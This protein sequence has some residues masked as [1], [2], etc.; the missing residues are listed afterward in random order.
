MAVKDDHRLMAPVRS[1]ASRK[2]DELVLRDVRPLGTEDVAGVDEDSQGLLLW[3]DVALLRSFR[4][5]AP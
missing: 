1:P 4:W 5:P 2:L 3:A